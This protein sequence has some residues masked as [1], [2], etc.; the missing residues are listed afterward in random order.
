MHNCSLMWTL[1]AGEVLFTLIYVD[2][3]P[4]LLVLMFRT[5]YAASWHWFLKQGLE[6]T[7]HILPC[8]PA[9]Q[10]LRLH[11]WH[12]CGPWIIKKIRYSHTSDTNIKFLSKQKH[13]KSSAN[14]HARQARMSRGPRWTRVWTLSKKKKSEN[15]P[16]IPCKIFNS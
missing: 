16:D 3:N 13:L 11:L 5:F 12:L 4:C 7:E 9:S 2:I 8:V 1:V 15:V 6:E 10:V 14:L